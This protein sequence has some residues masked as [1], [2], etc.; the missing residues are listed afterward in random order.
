MDITFAQFPATSLI[1]VTTLA[2]AIA[3]AALCGACGALFL[4]WVPDKIS[5]NI[6]S[7]PE[8]ESETNRLALAKGMWRFLT[9]LSRG[10]FVVAIVGILAGA[11]ISIGTMTVSNPTPSRESVVQQEFSRGYGVELTNDQARALSKQ[12]FTVC[13]QPYALT[14]V[15]IKN[16]DTG[17][18]ETANIIVLW[19]DAHR[20]SHNDSYTITVEPYK[21]V[22]TDIEKLP[23]VS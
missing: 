23:R 3:I 4:R 7:E 5:S 21:V 16:A 2:F 6:G 20:G 8:N 13:R 18:T 11:F 1:D 19:S 9:V 15:S 17:E 12:L 14:N 10:C 22:D